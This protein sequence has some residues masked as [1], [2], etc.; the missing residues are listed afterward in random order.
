M[1]GFLPTLP[2]A[3]AG[4]HGVNLVLTIFVLMA[5]A[6]L[7]AEIFERLG[8]P[9]VIGEILAGCI[10]GPSMLGWVQPTEVTNALGEVGV[11]F[12][13]FSVGLETPPRAIL[14]VGKAATLVAVLGVIIPFIGGWAV[15]EATGH[16]LIASLF[17]GAALVA[18]SVGI[19]AR[20]LAQLGQSRAASSRIVMGAAIIDDILGLLVLAAVASM[21][22]GKVN[23]AE[24]SLTTGMAIGF[25]VFIAWLGAPFLRKT[26]PYLDRLR[27]NHAWFVACV[28]L[29][30]GLAWA[31]AS[32]GVAAI[33]GAFLAG[34]AMA[35]PAEEQHELHHE[36]KGLTEFLVPFFL[37][38]IGMKLDMAVFRDPATLGLVA[39]LTVV[40]VLTKVVGCGAGAWSLGKRGAMQVGVGMVPRGEVGIVVAQVGLAAGVVDSR[41]FSVVVAVAVLTTLVVPPWLKVLFK[42]K[43]RHDDGDPR[44]GLK[45]A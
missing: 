10:V 2:L 5:A 31:A 14:R 24:L 35:E 43:P 11:M 12:L 45:A 7:L 21:A 17:G 27:V 8:Q 4:D 26:T 41:L 20:V 38:G 29:C 33:I 13:L 34:M 30:L 25:T 23:I 6:K 15:M 40:G 39:A 28:L 1:N 44:P 32:I 18:T 19:T 16:T 3:S 37:A 36:I 42:E 22:T 9:S